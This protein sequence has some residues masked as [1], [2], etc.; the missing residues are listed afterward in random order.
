[1][2]ATP[3]ELDGTER[4]TDIEI[5]VTTD[6]GTFEGRVTNS[7]GEPASGV[8]VIIFSDDPARWFEGSSYVR[9]TRTV[10]GTALN[11][12]SAPLPAAISGSSTSM[13]A[14]PTEPGRIIG[15]PLVPGRY[16]VIA[17]ESSTGTTGP[18]Y[19]P[20]TLEKLQSR[21]TFFTVTAGQTATVQLK[22]V[23]P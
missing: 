16:G 10:S 7:R 13:P 22:T 21:A 14:P 1:M 20:E 9:V 8:D 11:A 5:V 15:G 19:D 3:L 18:A 23:K 4:I 12:P 6:T 17:F 2:M